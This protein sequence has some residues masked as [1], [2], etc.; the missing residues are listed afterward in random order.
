MAYKYEEQINKRI[1]EYNWERMVEMMTWDDEFNQSSLD[2]IF[3]DF[4]APLDSNCRRALKQYYEYDKTGVHL[5]ESL[6]MLP[7]LD[8][9]CAEYDT[10]PNAKGVYFLGMIGTNPDGKTYY[11]VKIGS[12]DNIRTRVRQYATYNPMIYIGGYCV[13]DKSDAETLCHRYL[14]DNAYAVALH[15]D[16][17]YYVDEKTYYELCD[18]LSDMNMFKAIA[19]GR[20]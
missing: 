11:L 6:D 20:D 18:T 4:Q 3:R 15:T 8:M 13:I 14:R 7:V 17:W 5:R 19:E 12:S 10:L 1:K 2:L 9:P 16:E